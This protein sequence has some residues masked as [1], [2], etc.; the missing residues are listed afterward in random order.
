M[1]TND[2]F[3]PT[4][5]PVTNSPSISPRRLEGSA[6]MLGAVG[7]IGKSVLEI[8][9]I[10]TK[11]KVLTDL[12]TK[13]QSLDQ[14]A[15][16][17]R[18]EDMEK[19][20][21][22]VNEYAT[23][24]LYQQNLT[25]NPT[26]QTGE[27]VDAAISTQEQA[28][29]DLL[30]QIGRF[31]QAQIQGSMSATEF[32]NRALAATRE[33]V[34]LNPQL[35]SELLTTL[36]HH[37]TLSGASNRLEMIEK[38]NKAFLEQ[39]NSMGNK[40]SSELDK[41]LPGASLKYF[42]QATGL[43]NLQGMNAELLVYGRQKFTDD[44]LAQE[45]NRTKLLSEKDANELISSGKLYEVASNRKSEFIF[46]VAKALSTTKPEDLEATLLSLSENHALKLDTDYGGISQSNATI[47]T[48]FEGVKK[49]YESFSKANIDK[50]T[51]KVS[52]EIAKNNLEFLKSTKE[53]DF[54]KL[55]GNPKAL[56][57]FMELGKNVNF[58]ELI[59][60]DPAAAKS[61]IPTLVNLSL[62]SGKLINKDFSKLLPGGSSVAQASTKASVSIVG[63]NVSS[64]EAK[65]AASDL[66]NQS[67]AYIKN[68]TNQVEKYQQSTELVS[69]LAKE[70]PK[71]L[72][73]LTPVQKTD[74]ES[75]IIDNNSLYFKEIVKN[76]DKGINFSF[77]PEGLLATSNADTTFRSNVVDKINDSL[78][79]YANLKGVTTKAAAQEFYGRFYKDTFDNE[80]I[81]K[82]DYVAMAKNRMPGLAM[83]E[84]GGKMYDKKGSYIMPYAKP[85]DVP[86]DPKE[87]VFGKYQIMV[88]S[89][90]NPG[91]G[92]APLN[93]NL[94]GAAFDK[95]QERFATEYYTAL[96]NKYNG[97]EV[98]ALTAYNS[99]VG[100]VD[101][102]INKFGNDWYSK[103][104]ELYKKDKK[105]GL[106]PQG[107][108]YAAAV[109]KRSGFDANKETTTAEQTV[110]DKTKQ[111][112]VKEVIASLAPLEKNH[113]E[114]A[115]Q[116]YTDKV[117][118]AKY[119][120][121]QLLESG[122]N[123]SWE[124][125]QAF[126]EQE[127][128]K[129]VTGTKLDASQQKLDN[130]SWLSKV[131]QDVL[132]Y[133]TKEVKQIKE[134]MLRDAVEIQRSPVFATLTNEQQNYI[135][136][137]IDQPLENVSPEAWFAGGKVG[138]NM[139]KG[140]VNKVG[141]KFFARTQN[142]VN[143]FPTK[144]NYEPTPIDKL[145]RDQKIRDKFAPNAEERAM[146]R[147]VAKATE[148]VA[149][150]RA[151]GE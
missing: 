19:L 139:I 41:F 20:T 47:K 117:S 4:L 17:Q 89:A 101:N 2:V 123:M 141:P 136:G 15:F 32:K 84:S 75:I 29:N 110:I 130:V 40:L 132:G 57:L 62:G 65:T 100:R 108:A 109:F 149:K 54:I 91:L 21:G 80:A 70:D 119:I 93:F 18:P 39:N 118:K 140:I 137:I 144:T 34:A 92:V 13:L 106:G 122:I 90:M 55:V 46:D 104:I 56:E 66:I 53:E 98:K 150:T 27:E 64:P 88:G 96:L 11:E 44:Q 67:I 148:K 138:F 115:K 103:G 134:S 31:K 45:A 16:L 112:K 68:N 26:F 105:N 86:A 121:N 74:L 81:P 87:R 6:N 97:D 143:N 63:S 10:K 72:A 126:V 61:L 78:K 124:E 85:E 35:T 77:T 59:K 113:P 129:P 7:E 22:M 58:M 146:N 147:A 76:K 1:A 52:A 48:T 38:S 60:T 50:A 3:N 37:M 127:T 69:D 82:V 71:N 8:A 25:Q 131:S 28:K 12:N 30:G 125:V 99:G 116:F 94:S 114:L 43:W 142:V 23:Q 120:S 9:S 36:S 33:A 79:A 133:D 111:E 24:D 95:D 145:M 14:E 42:D 83:Q 102:L 151:R 73:A 5:Q 128:N 49:F 51:G 107:A 135:M